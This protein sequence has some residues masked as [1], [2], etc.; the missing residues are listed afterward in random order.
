MQLE[1]TDIVRNWLDGPRGVNAYLSAVPTEDG[2]E[3]KPV[4]M[5]VSSFRD[6]SMTTTGKFPLC[7]RLVVVGPAGSHTI[8]REAAIGTATSR[9][10]K[11]GIQY[12]VRSS[13]KATTLREAQYVLRAVGLSLKDLVL[14]ASDGDCN[15]R[16]IVTLGAT[17][18]ELLPLNET[19][20]AC[21]LLGFARITLMV[22]DT[23]VVRPNQAP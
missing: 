16:G 12:L 17:N 20:E 8:D 3:L 15:L 9:D 7:P 19:V 4:D 13:D 11:V 1:A 2:T 21:Q 5:V 14:Y 6:K 23:V 22:R 10:V 18:I